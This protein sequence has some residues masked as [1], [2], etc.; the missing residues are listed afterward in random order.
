MIRIHECTLGGIQVM[1]YV[2]R[3]TKL[4]IEEERKYTEDS[5]LKDNTSHEAL[6][7]TYS[8]ENESNTCYI[9]REKCRSTFTV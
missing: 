8:S 6:E 4:N 7:N 9:M 1:R 2:S 3:I 5:L